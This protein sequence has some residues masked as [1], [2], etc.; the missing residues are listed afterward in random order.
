MNEELVLVTALVCMLVDVPL[1]S[2]QLELTCQGTICSDNAGGSDVRSLD[3]MLIMF[4]VTSAWS[5]LIPMMFTS[6]H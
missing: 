3:A 4:T 2:R 1:E 6:A 5:I